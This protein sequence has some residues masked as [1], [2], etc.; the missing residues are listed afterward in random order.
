MR[1]YQNMRDK[2]EFQVDHAKL[3]EYFPMEV[4]VNGIFKIYEVN[5][6]QVFKKIKITQI[7]NSSIAINT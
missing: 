3:Q 4:V 6:S 1:Y 2:S 7:Q 5:F